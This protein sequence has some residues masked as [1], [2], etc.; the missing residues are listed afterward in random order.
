MNT[1]NKRYGIFGGSFDPIHVG[2]VIIAT[3]A[4]EALSLDRLYIV[5]AYIPPHKTSCNADFQTRFNWIKRVFKGE[6]KIF[7][8]DFEARR[9][10]TSYSIFTIRHFAALYGDKPFFLIG[11]DSF[12]ELDEWYS[13]QAILEEAIL[14]VYPRVRKNV[15]EGKP[16]ISPSE[17]NVHFLKAPLIEISS[18]E[19][20]ERIKEGKSILGM[21]PCSISEEVRAFYARK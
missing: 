20:R 7:V 11:E 16:P 10:D 19:I 18:T 6:N 1:W 4:I 14:V 17:R 9:G 12:Y 5:P 21:V 15:P 13:Y 8:S 3:R 2:H